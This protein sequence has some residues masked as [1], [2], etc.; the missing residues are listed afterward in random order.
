MIHQKS[1]K[2]TKMLTHVAFIGYGFVVLELVHEID[3]NVE[4]IPSPLLI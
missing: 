4:I 2:T 3:F 1:A